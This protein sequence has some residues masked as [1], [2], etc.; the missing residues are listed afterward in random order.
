MEE[1]IPQE[2]KSATIAAQ[3]EPGVKTRDTLSRK[4]V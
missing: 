3:A 1:I 4:E 2:G